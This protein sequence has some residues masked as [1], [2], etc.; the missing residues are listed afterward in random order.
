MNYVNTKIENIRIIKG[1][2]FDYFSEEGKKIFLEQEF[3]VSKLS[4]YGDETRRKKI[5]NIVDTNIK[6]EGLVRGVIQVPADETNYHAFRCGTIGDLPKNKG[7]YKCWL[8]QISTISAR[9]KKLK[10]IDLASAETLFKLY[11]LETQNL[12]SQI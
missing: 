2:N 1:T 5:E 4:E 8:R 3:S 12:I 10:E 7:S 6:S 11:E 9:F